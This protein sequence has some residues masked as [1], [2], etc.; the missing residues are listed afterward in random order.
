MIA[1]GSDGTTYVGLE[2]ITSDGAF[3][4]VQ[5]VANGELASVKFRFTEK[6]IL[7]GK[8][9]P[10]LSKI[11]LPHF[12]GVCSTDILPILPGDRKSVV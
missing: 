7:Y 6:H 10:Y 11:A 8:L 4:N 2:H 3:L 12:S 1:S 5:T 9:R